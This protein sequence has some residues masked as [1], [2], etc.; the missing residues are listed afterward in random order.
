[1]C[2]EI[3]CFICTKVLN[4][5]CSCKN[6]STLTVEC[7][8]CSVEEKYKI[9]NNSGINSEIPTNAIFCKLN[10]YIDNPLVIYDFCKENELKSCNPKESI[11]LDYFIKVNRGVYMSTPAVVSVSDVAHFLNNSIQK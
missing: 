8:K 7:N 2:V 10:G 1:M 6:I 4:W 3:K 5:L 9:L 11:M